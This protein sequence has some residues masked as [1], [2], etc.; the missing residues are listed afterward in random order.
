M[1]ST[2]NLAP[3]P[4]I[5]CRHLANLTASSQ[6][7]IQVYIVRLF[8]KTSWVHDT[9]TAVIVIRRMLQQTKRNKSLQSY[10]HIVTNAG[11]QKQYFA[12]CCH[13]HRRKLRSSGAI[14]YADIYGDSRRN[15]VFGRLRLLYDMFVSSFLFVCCSISQVSF[16]LYHLPGQ[17]R[18]RYTPVSRTIMRSLTMTFN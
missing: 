3:R 4:A 1:P 2:A 17:L 16:K 10:K 12:G 14:V 15:I 7:Y 5:K 8:L 6:K 11:D 18:G 9:R 13:K